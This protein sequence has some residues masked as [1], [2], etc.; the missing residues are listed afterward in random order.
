MKRLLIILLVLL[1][2]VLVFISCAKSETTPTPAPPPAPS[3]TPA[4]SPS[5]A[6]SPTTAPTP[7]PTPTPTAGAKYGDTLRIIL[8]ASPSSAG[9]LPADLFGNDAIS[10]Q[11]VVEPLFH[12]DSKGNLTPCLAESYK[13]AD[14]MKSITF[15]LRKGVK[16][17]DGSDFNAEAAKWNLDNIIAKKSQ[18]NWASV[19][20]IDDYTIRLNLTS[21]SNTI[22]TGIEGTT[23][24]VSPTTFEQ[25][26]ADWTR[27]NP[28]GTGPFKFVSFKRDVSYDVVK[29]PD[30]WQKGKPYLDGIKILYVT[31][32]LTQKAAIQAG[33]ADAL[34]IEPGK[35]A[36]DLQALGLQEKVNVVSTFCLLPDTA[37]PDSPF[38][39]QQVREA[40]E[41]AI[42]R[43]AIAKAF[44]YGFWTAPYQFPPPSDASF[45]PNFSLARK[46]DVGKAK[47]LLT[48]A[49]YP[50]GFSATLLV[51]PVGIDHNIPVAIQSNLADVGIKLELSFPDSIPKWIQDSNTVQ[52]GLVLQ[53]IFGGTNWNSALAFALSPSQTMMNGV[54]L[55]TPEFIQLYNASQ[56]SPVPDIN[57]IRAVNNYLSETAEVIPVFSGGSG[58]AYQS[59]VMDAYWNERLSYAWDAEDA[60]LNK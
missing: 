16:F 28:V 41:Y 17:H 12:V 24:M 55:R 47:Q 39:N 34:Q 58:Y 19:D 43:E 42:D 27:D 25:K 40:V 29:N 21:W 15:N 22:L 26:G 44:S 51:I 35:I 14:D 9:G 18:P 13:V 59:Y 57:L 52:N 54:W 10:C 60:W 48:E 4:P 46:Y 5:P 11:S 20:I 7:S 8:W 45:D 2:S 1:A 33:E 32:P 6:P 50:D 49:G 30:Y 3:T 31:D 37:H 56:S 53:P 38:A 36:S 23:L